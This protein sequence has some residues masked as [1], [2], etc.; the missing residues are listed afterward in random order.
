MVPPAGSALRTARAAAKRSVSLLVLQEFGRRHAAA[1]HL[2][3]ACSTAFIVETDRRFQFFPALFFAAHVNQ[4]LPA[5]VMNVGAA[6]IEFARG[7]NRAYGLRI[8]LL[9]LVNLCNP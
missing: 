7:V 8:L 9:M 3:L 4:N 5:Q 2:F 6:G 1:L